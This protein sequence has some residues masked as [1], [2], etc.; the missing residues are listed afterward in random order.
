MYAMSN[1]IAQSDA[2]GNLKESSALPARTG[3]KAPVQT[4][5]HTSP[6]QDATIR[7]PRDAPAIQTA[8]TASFL[9]E[10]GMAHLPACLA[11]S[12]EV[13]KKWIWQYSKR[14]R[15]GGNPQCLPISPHLTRKQIRHV[16]KIANHGEFSENP[17]HQPIHIHNLIMRGCFAI[18]HLQDTG[19]VIDGSGEIGRASC[20]ERV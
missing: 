15:P 20:R 16:P 4:F 5:L 2:N 13:A 18:L 11:A 12:Q 10:T 19:R 14:R 6:G 1:R 7:R 3:R 8:C 17:F 9:L